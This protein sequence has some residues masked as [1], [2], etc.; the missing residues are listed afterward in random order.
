MKKSLRICAFLTV[1]SLALSSGFFMDAQAAKGPAKGDE[2]LAYICFFNTTGTDQTYLYIS[3]HMKDIQTQQGVTPNVGKVKGATYDEKTNTLT[4]DGYNG[5]AMYISANMMGDNFK[6]LLKGD[7]SVRNLAVY[8]DGYGGSVT[9]KGRG[10]LTCNKDKKAAASVYGSGILLGAEGTKAAITI[11]DTCTVTSFGNSY[12]GYA[13]NEKRE[14]PG[15]MKGRPVYVYG[16]LSDKAE[17][18]IKAGGKLTGA[19]YKTV[20]RE[21]ELY[22]IYSTAG[23]FVSK[24]VK[25]GKK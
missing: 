17:E 23:R 7:N 10:T 14:Y 8:A 25:K 9:I 11:A 22:D 4:L 19:K 15:K 21:G 12:T 2:S 24:A 18:V 6:I 20:A 3:D 16:D 5:H 1:L 13:P